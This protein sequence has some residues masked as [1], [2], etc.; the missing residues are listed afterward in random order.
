MRTLATNIAKLTSARRALATWLGSGSACAWTRDRT[1]CHH[2][3]CPAVG[4]LI[5]AALVFRALPR[6][7]VGANRGKVS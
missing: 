7:A 4:T 2:T 5:V 3:R 1:V 6:F